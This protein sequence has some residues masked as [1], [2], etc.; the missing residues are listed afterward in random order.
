MILRGRLVADVDPATVT[1]EQLG[2]AMT[3]ADA[4]AS[5]GGEA[6]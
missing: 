5:T 1:P 6:A 3:G 4:G 2:A